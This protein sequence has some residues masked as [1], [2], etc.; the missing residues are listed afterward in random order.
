M[1]SSPNESQALT[2]T[3]SKF[4]PNIPIP[5]GRYSHGGCRFCV[6]IVLSIV[7]GNKV[8]RHS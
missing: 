1:N 2:P 4:N 5:G 6:E 7:E 3:H 8:F